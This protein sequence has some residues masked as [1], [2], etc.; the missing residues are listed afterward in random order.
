MTD[1][2]ITSLSRN[3]IA[4]IWGSNLSNEWDYIQTNVPAQIVWTDDGFS[5]LAY[6][7]SLSQQRTLYHRPQEEWETPTRTRQGYAFDANGN[8]Y[9]DILLESGH[10]PQGYMKQTVQGIGTYTI[11]GDIVTLNYN[12]LVVTNY[13]DLNNHY[14]VNTATDQEL[15]TLSNGRYFRMVL[16]DEYNAPR[17]IPLVRQADGSF[18]PSPDNPDGFAAERQPI[19]GSI[20][21]N[22]APPIQGSLRNDFLPGTRSRDLIAGRDGNDVIIGDRSVD[23]LEGGAGSDR[24]VFT[25]PDPSSA[26]IIK[27][28]NPIEDIL[29]VKT[30][31]FGGLASNSFINSN[32]FEVGSRATRAQTR[33]VYNPASGDVLFDADGSQG[34]A[35]VKIATVARNLNVSYTNFYAYQD[36]NLVRGIG[37]PTYVPGTG[38]RDPITGNVGNDRLVGTSGND[39]LDGGAGNDRLSSGNGDDILRGGEGNDVMKGGKGR[40]IFVLETGPGRDVI[41]DFRDRQDKLGL[42]PGMNFKKLDIEQRGNRTIISMGNDVLAILRGV[43]ESQI[44]AADFTQVNLG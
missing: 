35:T 26:D 31:A 3:D 39:F 28:F 16:G 36:L 9:V 44:T 7:Y 33:F 19:S 40:D 27:D 12:S 23:V 25:S 24:F 4:G 30:P 20:D 17:M 1:F 14:T 11:N 37:K 15:A 6:A 38:G 18:I 21:P 22:S 8:F 41:R 10:L 13:N 29:A 5:R 43:K 32:Q 2:S 42:L 34:G